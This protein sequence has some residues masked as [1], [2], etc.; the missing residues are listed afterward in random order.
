MA[1]KWALVISGG[2][3][4]GAFAVGAIKHLI[5]ERRM[6]FDLVVGTSTGALIAPFVVT[7]EVADLLNIYENVDNQDVL[8]NRPDLL[9]FLFSDAL[10]GSGPLTRLINRFV[11]NP[12]RYAKLM[13]SS[14]E[15]FVAMVNL[16]TGAV[17]YTS[18]HRDPRPVLLKSILASASVPVLMPPVRL[19]TSQYVDG[20]VKD[21]TPFSKAIEEGAT[22]IVAITLSPD[23]SRRRPMARKFSSSLDIMKRTLELLIQEV[24]DND[25]MLAALYNAGISSLTRVSA[26]ARTLLGLTA[27]QL[28]TLF[29]NVGDPFEGKRLIEL[30]L[31]RPDD[32]LTTD[33]L[34]FH[35]RA[36]RAMFD[37][38]RRKAEEVMTA[39]ERSSV[40]QPAATPA[41]SYTL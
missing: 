12:A 5:V 36:M 21:L 38:G 16:Q 11:G 24:G 6:M 7:H 35:P 40:A 29:T 39:R 8:T 1:D 37:L 18:Q 22:H 19:G 33:S 27:D 10:N 9:A 3:A 28:Q 25:V 4:K 26:N 23:A 2:G 34:R 41:L 15:L 30:T 31:I 14:V 13:A 20:G 17:E 32:E